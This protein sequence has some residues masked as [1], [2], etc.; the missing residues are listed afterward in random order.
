MRLSSYVLGKDL[1][2]QAD[3][4]FTAKCQ[5]NSFTLTTQ[6]QGAKSSGVIGVKDSIAAVAFNRACGDH[7][8]YMKIVNKGRN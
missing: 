4:F 1:T 2:K 5:E 8:A 6:G 3:Y 7:G